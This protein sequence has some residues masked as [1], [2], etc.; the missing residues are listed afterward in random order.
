M[1]ERLK[2]FFPQAEPTHRV[3]P[4]APLPPVSAA[5]FAELLNLFPIGSHINYCPKGQSSLLFNTLL[6]GYRING[7]DVYSAADFSF[8]EQGRLLLKHSPSSVALDVLDTVCFIAP[9]DDQNAS[10]LDYSRREELERFN[11]SESG[12]QL[13]V[14]GQTIGRKTP[15]VEA[16]LN[17]TQRLLDGIF[18]NQPV[19]LFALNVE[20]LTFYDQRNYF[21][22]QTRYPAELQ[23]ATGGD[24][25]ACDIRDFSESAAK[26]ELITQADVPEN[27]WEGRRVI[28]SLLLN[29]QT[30]HIQGR[31]LRREPSG[32]LVMRL[33][34]IQQGD[35][36]EP[37][38]NLDAMGIKSQILQAT[39]NQGLLSEPT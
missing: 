25:I 14:L 20:R 17:Q 19:N 1:L 18:A 10:R 35:E 28:L 23:P 13:T 33:E 4:V 3:T 29:D 6:I 24:L 31:I 27:L 26:L 16:R 5:Q 12:N 39:V 36:F 22:I 9:C 34:A 30:L 21:R 11:L 38:S 8:D 15:S 37:L 7:I 2:K 32:H